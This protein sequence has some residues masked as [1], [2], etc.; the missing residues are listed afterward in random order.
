MENNE[1]VV[2]E[3]MKNFLNEG[4]RTYAPAL[5]AISEFRRQI[6]TRLLTVLDDYSPELSRLGLAVDNLRFL[7]AKVDDLDSSADRFL[8]GL[9][10]NYGGELYAGYHVECNM[11]QQENPRVCVGAWVYVGTRA[12]RD[13]LF[14]II[15]EKRLLP[16]KTH[17]V[18][19]RNGKSRLFLPCDPGSF[20]NIN[21]V[22]RSLIEDWVGLLKT[23]GGIHEF[24]HGAPSRPNLQPGIVLE[25][26]GEGGSIKML[27]E[28]DGDGG[29]GFRVQTDESAMADILSNDDRAGIDSL[30]SKSPFVHSF[31]EALDLLDKYPWAELHPLFVRQGVLD[32]ILLEVRK[33]GGEAA[34]AR[35]RQELDRQ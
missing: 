33:R 11:E 30:T 9:E 2:S 25:I 28:S 15:Q 32:S 3:Q 16:S 22:F 12:G 13:H 20:F 21:E 35:W 5:A 7:D 14:Q 10:K 19:D 4:L 18:Q 31:E 17:L 26:G 34:E 29:W 6:Q 24:H 27:R 23:V 8:I 1:S